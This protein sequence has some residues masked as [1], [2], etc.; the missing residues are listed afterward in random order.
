MKLKSRILEI[1]LKIHAFGRRLG[2]A[3]CRYVDTRDVGYAGGEELADDA[4]LESIR[5]RIDED[6]LAGDGSWTA[7]LE[8]LFHPSSYKTISMSSSLS[9]QNSEPLLR[10]EGHQ[11]HK[12]VSFVP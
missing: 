7:T 2:R 8:K 12:V 5:T 11:L 6:L 9:V 4:S 1:L 3:L 10:K